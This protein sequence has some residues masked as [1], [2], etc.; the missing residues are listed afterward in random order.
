MAGFEAIGVGVDGGVRGEM[1]AALRAGLEA[2]AAHVIGVVA[3]G[4]SGEAA[5]D[6]EA[7][8]G[9]G[10]AFGVVGVADDVLGGVSMQVIGANESFEAD[11]AG[12]ADGA[13]IER[14]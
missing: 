10:A 2:T 14:L 4:V 12:E 8:F 6:G 7:A 1:Q 5:F 13:E 9:V 3:S 11:E